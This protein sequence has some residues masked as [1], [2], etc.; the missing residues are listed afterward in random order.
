MPPDGREFPVKRLMMNGVGDKQQS[1]RFGDYFLLFYLLIKFYWFS[2]DFK[3]E[4]LNFAM[5]FSAKKK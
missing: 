4:N 5:N 2:G 1:K 3:L